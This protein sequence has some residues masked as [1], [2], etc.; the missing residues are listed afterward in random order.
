MLNTNIISY[1]IKNRDFSL[2]DKFEEMSKEHIIAV[3]SITVTEL[4]YGVMKKNSK[5]LEVTVNEFLLP[6]QR[7]AFD[8]NTSYSY[9]LIRTTLESKG[10]IIGS[11][12]LFIA[13]HAKSLDAVLV[14]NNTR[15][16]ERIENLK[17]QDW[18]KFE[19][20]R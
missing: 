18:T 1:I 19:C 12:D 11:D 16:F 9:A 7:L 4:F 13:A 6:L 17:I 20:Y 10:L 8:E 3:S 14:T 5:K 2:I 15:E